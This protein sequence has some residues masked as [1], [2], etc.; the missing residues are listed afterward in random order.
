[1][2][3][4]PLIWGK[5]W[6]TYDSIK[7]S[8]GLASLIPLTFIPDFLTLFG[9]IAMASSGSSLLRSDAF[10]WYMRIGQLLVAL[11]VLGIAGN[12]VSL[13]HDWDCAAPSN[14][15]FNVACVRPVISEFL[16]PYCSRLPRQP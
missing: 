6:P 5:Q 2:A 15:S 12:N 10:L 14:L 11:I 13:W 1:M 9:S 3:L 7:A 16:F 4:T 8:H